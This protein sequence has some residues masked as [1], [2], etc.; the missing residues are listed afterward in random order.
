MTL[1][2]GRVVVISTDA[3]TKILPFFPMYAIIAS[4]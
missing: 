3:E 4:Q 2:R 1:F